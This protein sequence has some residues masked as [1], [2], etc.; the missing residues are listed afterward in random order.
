MELRALGGL[1]QGG[2]WY[3]G[4]GSTHGGFPASNT[5]G[6]Q[7]PRN[8]SLWGYVRCLERRGLKGGA[9]VSRCSIEAE[10]EADAGRYMSLPFALAVEVFL[11]LIFLELSPDV[12]IPQILR[13]D[14]HMV[15]NPN[16]RDTVP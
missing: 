8:S 7:G 16:S 1:Q 9:L 4:F 11:F 14:K 10:R 15:V 12:F 3:Q 2:I 5:V 6:A 13:G